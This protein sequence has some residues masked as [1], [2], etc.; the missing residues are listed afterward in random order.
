ML[1][2]VDDFLSLVDAADIDHAGIIYVSQHGK[3]V[4]ELVRRLDALLEDCA[5]LSPDGEIRYA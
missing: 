4:G 2:N 5:G 1:R 3:N